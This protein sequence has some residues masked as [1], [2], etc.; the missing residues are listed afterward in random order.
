MNLDISSHGQ[1]KPAGRI[2]QKNEHLILQA[3]EIEFARHGYKGASVGKIAEQAGL[4]KA[5]I[6]YY[7]KNKRSL[8]LAVLSD[9][10][11]LWD[12]TLSHI[13]PDDDPAM[14]LGNYIDLKIRQA[15]QHPLASKIFATEVI[16]GAPNLTQ[17]F[18]DGYQNWFEQRAEVFRQWHQQGK[19]DDVSPAHLIFLIWSSTQHYADFSVQVSAA[20]GKTELDNE[21]FDSAASTLKQIILKG[22]GINITASG[23]EQQTKPLS[24]MK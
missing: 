13:S 16:S 21:D 2:R 11:D 15:Q 23:S 18:K 10:I 17:Y 19:M 8:Y 3:A 24:Q 9:I 6:H 12:T 7:F 20:L 5:N 1:E 4:P 14:V 22:C